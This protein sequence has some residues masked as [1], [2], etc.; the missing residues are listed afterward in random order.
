MIDSH[1]HLYLDRYDDDRDAV[2]QR[3]RDAGV[4]HFLQ[5]GCTMEDCAAVSAMTQSFR[6][7][8]G[9]VG[10]HPHHASE[11]QSEY[12]FDLQQWLGEP[13][14]VALGEIGLDYHYDYSPRDLQRR[15][16]IQ[17][18]SLAAELQTPVVIHTREA[19]EDTLNILRDYPLPCGAQVHCFTGSAAF[20]EGCLGLG[21]HIGFTGILCFKNSQWLR[22]IAANVPLNRLLME[23]DSPYM[24]PPPHRGKRNEPAFVVEVAKELARL[25]KI[26]LPSLAEAVRANFFQLFPKIGAL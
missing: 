15:V 22:E 13:K 10:I 21:F 24:A 5:V 17:Q 11:W 4:T 6:D 2:F 23:T 20:A 16:F 12:T 7:T 1:S 19:E 9:A 14:I 8:Y 25:H 26:D 3:A 18:L